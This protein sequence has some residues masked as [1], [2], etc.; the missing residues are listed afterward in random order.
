M[1]ELLLEERDIEYRRTFGRLGAA[2]LN[3]TPFVKRDRV[4][5]EED[6][7]PDYRKIEERERE[8]MENQ[9]RFLSGLMGCGPNNPGTF[10]PK[11]VKTVH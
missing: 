7:F 9:I 2:L 4:I 5:D 6:F 3:A 10:D 1:F 8:R 11:K